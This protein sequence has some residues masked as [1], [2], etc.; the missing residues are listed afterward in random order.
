MLPRPYIRSFDGQ[1]SDLILKKEWVL[2]WEKR[3]ETFVLEKIE[4]TIMSGDS[5]ENNSNQYWSFEAKIDE[6]K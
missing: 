2:N 6:G 4:S 1:C 5:K 3:A